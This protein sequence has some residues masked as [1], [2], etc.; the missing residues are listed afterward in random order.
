MNGAD[1]TPRDA[2]V[3]RSRLRAFARRCVGATLPLA[4]LGSAMLIAAGGREPTGVEL[5]ATTTS[6]PITIRNSLEGTAILTTGSMRPGGSVQGVVKITNAGTAAAIRLSKS[7]LTDVL[8]R[9]GGALSGRLQLTVEDLAKPASPIV[10]SGPLS[11]LPS[12]GLGSFASG[13]AH[14]FRLTVTLPNAGQPASSSTGDNRYQGSSTSVQFDWTATGPG[15]PVLNFTAPASQRFGKG[16]LVRASCTLA[17]RVA[18]GGSVSIAGSRTTFRLP[19]R[20]LS[21]KASVATGT[22]LT[23]S[24]AART[25]IG[26]ALKKHKKVTAKVTGALPGQTAKKLSVAITSH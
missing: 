10:Y 7:H 24:T 25:A 19:S 1:Q 18:V 9:F 2:A 15:P 14:T 4:V 3:T 20:T 23:F 22:T 5:T 21:L 6:G 17:C 12:L 16:V 8:G 13:E 26:Q 11:S